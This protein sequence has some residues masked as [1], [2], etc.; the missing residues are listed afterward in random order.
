M[1][2]GVCRTI[3]PPPCG[4]NAVCKEGTPYSCGWGRCCDGSVCSREKLADCTTGTWL[5]VGDKGRRDDHQS[6]DRMRTP[7]YLSEFPYVVLRHG[8][9]L[10]HVMICAAAQCSFS[11]QL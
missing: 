11:G 6:I 5:A 3:S 9:S 1:C 8:V 7:L 2:G 10:L 4:T